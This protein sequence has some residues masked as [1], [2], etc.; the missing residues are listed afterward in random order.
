MVEPI[1]VLDV[2]TNGSYAEEAPMEGF[3]GYGVWFGPMHP[4]N[5]SS[6]LTGPIQTNNRAQR[7]FRRF[8]LSPSRPIRVTLESKYVYDGVTAHMHR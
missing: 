5:I 3:A 7:V 4:H 2:Y 6:F 8:R 1:H